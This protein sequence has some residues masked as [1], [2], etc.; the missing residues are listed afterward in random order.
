MEFGSVQH[1][2]VDPSIYSCVQH[3][4]HELLPC[5]AQPIVAMPLI[6]DDDLQRM[7]KMRIT[8]DRARSETTRVR[9]RR[10]RYLDTHPEY[11]SSDLELAGRKS[12]LS[13]IAPSRSQ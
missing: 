10:K 3:C 13:L 4:H 6:H 9:N 11:L 8:N 5:L 2:N 1:I 12:K 7:E